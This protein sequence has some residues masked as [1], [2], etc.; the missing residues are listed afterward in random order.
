M[1]HRI[2]NRNPGYSDFSSMG[3]PQSFNFQNNL[4]NHVT[5]G[6]TALK[7]ETETLNENEADQKIDE[8][9]NINSDVGASETLLNEKDDSLI[10]QNEIEEDIKTD[11]NGLENFGIEEDT[12]D[13]F[14][15]RSTTESPVQIQDS[16]DENSDE[17]EF[18]IPAYLRRQKN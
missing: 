6:A 17:E 1:V 4:P 13:L 8:I 2:Q 10:L 9:I 5:E 12:P 3:A 18:E 14:E 15:N 16:E 11:S 7:T